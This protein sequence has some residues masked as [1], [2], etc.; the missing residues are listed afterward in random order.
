MPFFVGEQKN[1]KTKSDKYRDLELSYVD[2][3]SFTFEAEMPRIPNS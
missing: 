2:N 3:P 1:T